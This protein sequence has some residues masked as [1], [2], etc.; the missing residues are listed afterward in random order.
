MESLEHISAAL[1]MASLYP[2]LVVIAVLMPSLPVLAIVEMYFLTSFLYLSAS[3][4]MVG[5]SLSSKRLIVYSALMILL[6]AVSELAIWIIRPSETTGLS[7]LL[8]KAVI[9]L[10]TGS[11][12]IIMSSLLRIDGLKIRGLL[13]VMGS[14]LVVIP[15][16]VPAIIGLILM[17]LGC[18]SSSRL[19]A[20]AL[21]DVR[22]RE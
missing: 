3:T 11:S 21:G 15:Y 19:I 17:F 8:S 12:L 22:E 13:V 10:L 20:T 6:L 4:Y 18:W 9:Y 2:A 14:G 5:R 1:M 16:P 7:V